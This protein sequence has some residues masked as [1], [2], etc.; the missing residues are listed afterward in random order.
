MAT[1][2]RTF[3]ASYKHIN[4]NLTF[5]LV[6]SQ[7]N[8]FK[9]HKTKS[10]KST[11]QETRRS[12]SLQTSHTEKKTAPNHNQK[13]W[14]ITR[15]SLTPGSGHRARPRK[16]QN[17][18]T[19][20]SNYRSSEGRAGGGKREGNAA[21]EEGS[22][23]DAKCICHCCCRYCC[24]CEGE[25]EEERKRKRKRGRK[26]F[27]LSHCFG[28]PFTLFPNQVPNEVSIQ[29]AFHFPIHTR[30]EPRVHSRPLYLFSYFG[31]EFEIYWI[32]QNTLLYVSKYGVFL[33]IIILFLVSLFM[34]FLF[35]REN[36]K[37]LVARE[38]LTIAWNSNTSI[39]EC[40]KG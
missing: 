7:I 27:F 12:Q 22:E 3:H 10:T 39:Q 9:M 35:C 17:S 2:C 11:S 30:R 4:F 37:D 29:H 16:L 19:R 23:E 6:R 24:C 20:W 26:R 14:S 18:E 36:L 25:R 34:W 38:N 33:P 40:T 21:A 5:E 32:L 15:L 1:S 31:Y 28:S 8:H 13:S